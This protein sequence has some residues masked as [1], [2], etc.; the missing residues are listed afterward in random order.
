MWF[1]E[2]ES[3]PGEHAMKTAEMTTKDLEYCTNLVDKTVAGFEKADSNFEINS[4]VGKML[5]KQHCIVQR[6]HLSKE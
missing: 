2:M 5:S 1:F 6:S 4:T 3:T